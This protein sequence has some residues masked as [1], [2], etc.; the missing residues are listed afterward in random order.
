MIINVA[1]KGT[2]T[3]SRKYSLSSASGG[4]IT[5]DFSQN[6]PLIIGISLVQFLI[7]V[8]T[9]SNRVPV[10]VQLIYSVMI[11]IAPFVFGYSVMFGE[12]QC[13]SWLILR[14]LP[15]SRHRVI[16][17][18]IFTALLLTFVFFLCSAIMMVANQKF[19]DNSTIP[20]TPRPLSNGDYLYIVY[21]IVCCVFT[22]SAAALLLPRNP[23]LGV[24]GGMFSVV[25]W[26]NVLFS[27]GDQP[28]S[29]LTSPQIIAH[30]G[31]FMAHLD[32][33]VNLIFKRN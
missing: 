6:I 28:P 31:T 5:K 8:I 25:F 22:G 23:L 7:L 30:G 27:L 2:L 13:N 24:I 16:A 20:R 11:W 3:E 19:F 1:S 4:I 21:E 15:I 33:V 26:F 17:R 9:N 18:K 10:N 29:Y 14:A 32:D 12:F